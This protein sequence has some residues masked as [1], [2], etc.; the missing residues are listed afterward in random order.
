MYDF[1]VE[2]FKEDIEDQSNKYGGQEDPFFMT[3]TFKV[4]IW[5]MLQLQVT[6]LFK[7]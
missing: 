1:E 3:A 4:Q 6:T 5:I 2:I 7:F